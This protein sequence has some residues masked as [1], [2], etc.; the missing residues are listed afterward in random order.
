MLNRKYTA[1]IDP[2]TN[3]FK[4]VSK[5]ETKWLN[6]DKKGENMKRKSIKSLAR[7]ICLLPHLPERA[8]AKAHTNRYTHTED[9][10]AAGGRH[11]TNLLINTF[12]NN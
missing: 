9:P 8:A 11:C 5:T 3:V 4:K 1:Y 6:C 10:Q 7:A 12:L 2:A